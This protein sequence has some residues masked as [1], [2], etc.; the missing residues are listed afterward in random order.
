MPENSRNVRF[1]T[2]RHS[3]HAIDSEASAAAVN[4]IRSMIVFPRSDMKSENE[5]ATLENAKIEPV[6]SIA[7]QTNVTNEPLLPNTVN[8]SVFV[9]NQTAIEN[10]FEPMLYIDDDGVFRVKYVTKGENVSASSAKQQ[11]SNEQSFSLASMTEE[12]AIISNDNRQIPQDHRIP[13]KGH[14]T[15]IDLIQNNATINNIEL[16][17][18]N[19]KGI[20]SR[21]EP[22]KQQPK[23]SSTNKHPRDFSGQLIF[24]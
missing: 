6:V 12:T 16:N 15:T 19:T 3:I 11:H 17:E 14:S 4:P 1:P 24:V 23:P 10:G 22:Q 13:N 5:L 21:V 18:A 2:E 20:S 9:A 7:I 8:M